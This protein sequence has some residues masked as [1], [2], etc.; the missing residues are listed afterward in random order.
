MKEINLQFREL[1]PGSEVLEL[2]SKKL[3]YLT[4]VFPKISKMNISLLIG[5]ADKFAA[6]GGELKL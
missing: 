6:C 3:N 4:D 2:T 1:S 5:L